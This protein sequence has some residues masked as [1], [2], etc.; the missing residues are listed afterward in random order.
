VAEH[1]GSGPGAQHVSVV[2][3]VRPSDQGV[4]QG[5][6]LAARTVMA[7]PLA[8]VDQLVGDRLDAEPLGKG[9][10]QQQ[11]SVS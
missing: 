10:R 1:L 7:G 3:A 11:A 6:H 5:Q 4:N 2:D 9:G 8:K